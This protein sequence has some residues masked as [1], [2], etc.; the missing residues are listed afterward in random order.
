MKNAFFVFPILGGILLF[1]VLGQMDFTK[2]EIQ[3][4]TDYRYKSIDN[5]FAL[6]NLVIAVLVDDTILKAKFCYNI[7]YDMV[8]AYYRE[9]NMSI[10][11]FGKMILKGKHIC[12]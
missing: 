12:Q 8:V 3:E 10:T 4:K 2:Q 7:S 11:P 6:D 9:N 1:Y 5:E